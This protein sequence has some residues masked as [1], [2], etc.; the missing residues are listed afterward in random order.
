MIP[1]QL[2]VNF[3]SIKEFENF[4]QLNTYAIDKSHNVNCTICHSKNHKM[5]VQYGY[6]NNEPCNAITPCQR[7]TKTQICSQHCST[8]FIK[9]NVGISDCVKGIIDDLIY[10]Y[11]ARPKRIHIRLNKKKMEEQG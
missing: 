6:C 7:R 10:N 8:E 11:D 3:D 4:K 2:E 5:K 9:K 1:W